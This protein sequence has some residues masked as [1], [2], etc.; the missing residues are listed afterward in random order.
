[1]S[2]IEKPKFLIETNSLFLIKFLIKKAT[3]SIVTN[4]IISLIIDGYLRNER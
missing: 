2:K 4:G 1:M 3:P